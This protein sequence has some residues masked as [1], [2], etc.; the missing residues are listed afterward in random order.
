MLVRIDFLVSAFPGMPFAYWLK[1]NN[2][3]YEKTG[4]IQH[5]KDTI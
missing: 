5:E 3:K 4:K 1:T 2:L